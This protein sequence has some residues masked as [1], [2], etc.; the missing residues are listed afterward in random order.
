MLIFFIGCSTASFAQER[1]GT[2]IKYQ[3]QQQLKL[4][5]SNEQFEE[6]LKDKVLIQ[7]QSRESQKK[8]EPY[9]IPIV[10]HIVHNGEAIGTGANIPTA[11]VLSQIKV[12]ND[13][14]RRM[15]A[16]AS[17]TPE[18]FAAVAGSLDIEF[19]LAK[20]DPEGIATS[21]IVRVNGNRA[22]WTS[23]DNV[24]LKAVSYWPAEDY[25]N[26]WVCNFTDFIGLAQF[27]V[28]DL[29]GL[30]NSP[31]NRLT[32]GIIVSHRAFGSINDG[33]FDLDMGYD[34]GR[35]ITHET[36]HFF[37]LKHIWGDEGQCSGSDHVDDTPNQGAATSGCPGHPKTTC[38]SDDMFQNYL[39]YTNDEC[40]NLFTLGQ[41]ARM[42]I[43][44]E[45]SPR[46]E[47]LLT[48]PGLNAADPVANDL[49]I[50]EIINP[51]ESEC[52][53]NVTPSIEI[54]NYGNNI[55]T[56]ASIRL[57][58]QN[59]VVETKAVTMNLAPLEQMVVNFSPL[60]LDPGDNLI[61]F[62]I[63]STNGSMDG[64]D[65]SNA[66][67]QMANV[68]VPF[69]VS[70]PFTEPFDDIPNKWRLVNPDGQLTWQ[71]LTAPYYRQTNTALGVDFFN[72]KN[73][74]GERDVMY[75][76]AFNLSAL[77]HPVLYFDR[78]HAR[79]GFSHDR[80]TI[81]A[82]RSC[83]SIASG[84]VVYDK[85]GPD[86]A[87]AAQRT[88]YYMPSSGEWSR[89]VIDLSQFAD[90]E[91][92][93]LAFVGTNDYGNNLYIDNITVTEADFSDLT[94]SRLVSPSRFSCNEDV[95]MQVEVNNLSQTPVNNVELLISVN[96][97]E[98]CSEIFNNLNL[99]G[100]TT[101]SVKN[102]QL[103]AG[104]N[105]IEIQVNVL[106]ETSYDDA[107]NN[108]LLSQ[109]DVDDN[110]DIIPLRV[111]F[112]DDVHEKWLSLNSEGNVG[113]EVVD[114]DGGRAATLK[115]FESMNA[116]EENWFVSPLL[117]FSNAPETATML[118]DLSYRSRAYRTERLQ[119]LASRD[120]GITY[121]DVAFHWP[122]PESYDEPWH[123]TDD[124]WT[125]Q[126]SVDLHAYAGE[127]D[128]RLAFAVTN[129]SGNNIY[130]DNIEIFDRAAP[131]DFSFEL[132][133]NVFGYNRSNPAATQLK[134]GF[135]LKDRSDVSCAIT[136]LS[137]RIVAENLWH[138]VLN[139]VF[140]LPTNDES[141]TNGIYFV[142]VSIGTEV[143]VTKIII[144][145]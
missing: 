98:C 1:C 134:I 60:T 9:K 86:L 26:I 110:D 76:P 127:S 94:V 59:T 37:G 52:A 53:T 109:I 16:D 87:T 112:E 119:I 138:N 108:L 121:E 24:D 141:Y 19:V 23:N 115:A 88:S 131:E 40:M 128:V 75:S 66:N 72:Y 57:L 36:G 123:P 106:D 130:V 38:Q 92:L 33:N 140:P 25:M 70:V 113:W 3:Q 129:L 143:Y 118:F 20:R 48:S 133:F 96:G 7:A 41:V 21:G 46:R 28:S 100:P 56:S 89:E 132:P 45:N 91:S 104:Q 74:I 107:S 122:T 97:S 73:G 51:S 15:N 42:R 84:I 62:E 8:D 54:R 78:S 63:V 125:R 135:N 93:Q 145:R 31:N 79:F 27:P 126:I 55:V 68:Y 103:N 29:P 85:V 111:S 81:V 83:E 120:C 14:F 12:L 71:I 101:L 95:E 49:G 144:N 44:I 11:Q 105:D 30:E 17:Q 69:H 6:W 116:G 64:D 4:V 35:T 47:S 32:D 39:D 117:D 136:D 80:L 102:V 34:R 90:E 65:I 142:R 2:A 5:D 22:G 137:G 13:D 124:E 18:E 10:V 50:R 58:F 61:T 67:T 99:T 77:D 43:V 82:I 139:Q 114:V